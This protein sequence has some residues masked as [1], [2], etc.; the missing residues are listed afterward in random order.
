MKILVIGSGGREHT[1]AWKI[2]QSPLVTE[3]YCAP[4]NGGMS[5]IATCISIKADDIDSLLKFAKEKNID[6][7]IVG[8][9]APLVKG[10]VDVFAQEGICIFGPAKEAAQLE[11][12]KVF[13]KLVMTKYGIPTASHRIFEHSTD[14]KNYLVNAEP[15]FVIKADGLAAGKGVII[16]KTT[17]EAV[18]AVTKI[19]EDKIFGTAGNKIIIEDFIEGEELSVLAFTDGNIIIP[20]A[21]SQDH[22]RA[23]NDDEGPNTGGM[24]AY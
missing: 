19:L 15:P 23:Y 20:L 10:I 17:S 21:S 16:A 5:T 13:A 4:G 18:Q 8:P 7:T 3:L 9:E 12:S 1:L 6:L 11:G 2:K 22:K 14:A 24:G